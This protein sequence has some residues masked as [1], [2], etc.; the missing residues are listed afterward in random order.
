MSW[1]LDSKVLIALMV[2]DHVH[3]VPA[4][5]WFAGT[6]GT[7][8]TCPVTQGALIRHLVRRGLS[9]DRARSVLLEITSHRRHEFWADDVSYLDVALIGVLGHRQVTDAYLAQLA[10]RRGARVVTFD[11]GLAHLRSGVTE[12]VPTG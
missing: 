6:S 11:R 7:I 3:N 8:A 5:R 4:S 1:L 10:L 9:A 12:L 2:D